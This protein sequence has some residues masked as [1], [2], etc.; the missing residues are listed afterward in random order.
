LNKGGNIFIGI[1]A[2]MKRGERKRALVEL[3]GDVDHISCAVK[4]SLNFYSES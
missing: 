2:E 3:V 4:M 1:A